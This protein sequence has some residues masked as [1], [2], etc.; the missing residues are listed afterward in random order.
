MGSRRSAIHGGNSD[1]RSV[2]LGPLHC[3]FP[4]PR[5]G[6][7][8]WLLSGRLVRSRSRRKAFCRKLGSL[9]SRISRSTW[10]R[11]LQED[12]SAKDLCRTRIFDQTLNGSMTRY[13]DGG[14]A[15]DGTSRGPPPCH[16]RCLSLVTTD[17]SILFAVV[18]LPLLGCRSPETALPRPPD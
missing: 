1:A 16:R 6:P 5:R 15:P 2:T 14:P 3:T 4:K 13:L 17:T 11:A 7:Q 10:R 12:G 8:S 18:A 9:P